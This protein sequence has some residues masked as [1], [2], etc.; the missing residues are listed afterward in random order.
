MRIYSRDDL[1]QVP[2]PATPDGDYAR[3]VLVPWIQNG[4]L[5]YFHNVDAE[6]Q[7]LEADGQI[8][9]LVL[10]NLASRVKNSYVASP[11]SHYV[12]YSREEMGIELKGYPALRAV[13]SPMVDVLE[14]FFAATRLEGV[15]LVNNWLL[16]TNL[17]PA[18]ETARLAEIS[19]L[20]RETYPN[21]VIVFRSVNTLLNGRI[22]DQLMSLD[23]EPVFS[24]QVYIL[25]PAKKSYLGKDSYKRD[26]RIQRRTPYRWEF[27]KDLS[28]AEIA[29][30]VDLYND[31][32]L[33]KY[34]HLNPQFNTRFMAEAIAQDWLCFEWLR[35]PDKPKPDAMIGWFE[36]DGVMTAPLVGYDRSLPESTGLFRLATL[37][38]LQTAIARDWILHQSSGV[39]KY[40]MHRG[41]EPAMEYNMVYARHCPGWRRMPWQT[42][43]LLTEKLLEPMM[44]RLGL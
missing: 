22:Y 44:T 21:R 10:G 7:V 42:L 19:E 31:L 5:S 2:W 9:P 34:S 24:R 39:S 14:Y 12:D 30:L 8:F 20:L 27:S 33:A 26:L 40:K 38:L 3:R 13:L 32:Y 4:T 29:H 25:D 43:R 17:Y 15:V 35:H 16:S 1:N 41:A 23:Y 6:I 36:R 28:Q 18:F 37:R 11:M